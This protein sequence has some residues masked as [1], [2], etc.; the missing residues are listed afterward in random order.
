MIHK[1]STRW[2]VE[3][4]EFPPNVAIAQTLILKDCCTIEVYI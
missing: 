1:E 3:N 2:Q 4:K